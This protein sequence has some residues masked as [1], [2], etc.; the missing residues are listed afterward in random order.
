MLKRSRRVIAIHS[1][2]VFVWYWFPF[3]IQ[4][5]CIVFSP[6]E[7]LLTERNK[8]ASVMS[9]KHTKTEQEHTKQ[10]QQ[11]EKTNCK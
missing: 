9:E 7:R 10:G 5:L 3:S 6:L 4:F 2:G 8:E 1:D 11:E